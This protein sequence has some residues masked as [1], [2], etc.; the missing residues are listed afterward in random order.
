MKIVSFL[1]C[2][3]FLDSPAAPAAALLSGVLSV[4]Y[5]GIFTGCVRYADILGL[6][7]IPG[8]LLIIIFW[9]VLGSP[10]LSARPVSSPA[11]VSRRGRDL[12]SRPP[13]DME[14]KN[15]DGQRLE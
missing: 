9:A 6:F 8:S 14:R 13:G 15:M 3:D 2:L 1:Y 5:G 10:K 4:I 7:R 12:I 11:A